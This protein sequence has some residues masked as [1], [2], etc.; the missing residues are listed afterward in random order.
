M[1][2]GIFIFLSQYKKWKCCFV[3]NAFF[4]FIFAIVIIGLGAGALAMG[5]KV[6]GY[7]NDSKCIEKDTDPSSVE[8]YINL[9]FYMWDKF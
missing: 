3:F 6:I 1:I 7:I 4:V 9:M 2:V 8:D 5:G